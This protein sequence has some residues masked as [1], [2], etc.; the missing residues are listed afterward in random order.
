MVVSMRL[1][2]FILLIKLVIV[3]AQLYVCWKSSHFLLIR[4]PLVVVPVLLIRWRSLQLPADGF[5]RVL[6]LLQNYFGC[7]V[8][9]V[10][11]G[12]LPL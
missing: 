8:Y 9:L 1:N 6:L 3:T 4:L 7:E 12:R 11:S 5:E 2:F 10:L